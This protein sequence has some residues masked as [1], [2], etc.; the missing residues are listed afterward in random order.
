M[1]GRWGKMVPGKLFTECSLKVFDWLV[2]ELSDETDS[3]PKNK[4]ET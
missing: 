2:K 4:I 3:S 1:V